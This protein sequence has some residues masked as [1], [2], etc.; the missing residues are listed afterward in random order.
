MLGK[1]SCWAPT[2][3]ETLDLLWE[4][5]AETVLLGVTTNVDFLRELLTKSEVI[6]S[7]YD[8]SYLE[9]L[10]L[11]RPEASPLVFDSYAYAVSADYRVESTNGSAWAFDNWRLSGSP[12]V[13]IAAHLFGERTNVLPKKLPKDITDRLSFFRSGQDCWLHH[14]SFGTWNFKTISDRRSH[15]EA[16]SSGEITSPMPGLV[17]SINVAVGDRV[18]PGDSLIVIEAMKMEHVVRSKSSGTVHGV[19]VEVG[20]NIK[21][22]QILLE[23]Q[24]DV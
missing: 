7:K 21:A 15:A 11:K 13:E 5:L 4:A 17:I 24:H 16:S 6:H 8:T 14:P 1:I 20:L 23:I 3:A 2:R 12:P 19:N 9:K 18:A 22:G 10:S